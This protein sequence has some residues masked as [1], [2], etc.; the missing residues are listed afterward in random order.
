[1]DRIKN[2]YFYI[3]IGYLGILL[4]SIAGLRY[5]LIIDDVIGCGLIM[6]GL[7]FI[8]SNLRFTESKLLTVKE[9][10]IVNWSFFCVTAI[11][12]IIGFTFV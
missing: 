9:R 6:F 3:V 11:I 5:I 1:M 12:C 7:I 10:R 4:I 2:H 8:V